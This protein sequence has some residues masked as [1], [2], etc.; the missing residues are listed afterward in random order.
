MR[1]L[2]KVQEIG[3]EKRLE[4]PTDVELLPN[5]N[6]L[7]TD[8]GYW[9]GDGSEILEID[10]IGNIVWQYGGTLKFAHSAKLLPNG[11]LLI[12]DTGNNR[13]FEITR[14]GE[15]LM[16]SNQWG[17]G[18]GRLSDGTYLDY[19]NDAH[20]LESGTLLIT[21][22]NNNRVIECDKDGNIIRCWD[23]V[24][25]PHNG[26]ML[27]NGNLLVAS[28]DDNKII[29]L[30]PEGRVVWSYGDGSTD[31]LNWPRD[32]DR[33]ENGNTLIVDSKNHRVIEVDPKG[34]IVWEY[35]TEKRSQPYD[36]DRLSD[37]TTLISFQAS[38]SVAIIDDS[39]N[40][41]W[42]FHNFFRTSALPDM[43]VN[44]DFRTPDSRLPDKPAGWVRCDL[45]SEGGGRFLW[46]KDKPDGV[47]IEYNR[48]GAMW[49]QQTVKA[50]AGDTYLLSG[51]VKTEDLD[52]M[53]QIQLAFV[54]EKGCFIHEPKSLPGGKVY[55]GTTDWTLDEAQIT[56]P[57]RTTGVDIRLVVIGKGTVWF[58][59]IDFIELPWF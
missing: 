57:D 45:L 54:D 12:A 8:A 22:R 28:S 42:N 27:P 59:K 5:G 25:H 24:N 44:G 39:G 37:G 23:S 58:N 13:V 56:A 46:D 55:T 4:F 17:D 6:I 9:T 48:D 41:L 21:D 38:S 53:A 29:E 43:I 49:W 3:I 36:A 11:N 14:D 26:D 47:G 15:V 19:P 16:D 33:L 51:Q 20:Q 2:D 10:R 35:K 18:T 1:A 34:N 32:A 31:M 50:S 30:D 52:G 7:V 40:R